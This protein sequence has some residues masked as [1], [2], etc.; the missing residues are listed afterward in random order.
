MWRPVSYRNMQETSYI[1]KNS[2]FIIGSGN[3]VQLLLL[4]NI[5]HVHTHECV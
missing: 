1:I 5:N 2:F 4:D 3:F